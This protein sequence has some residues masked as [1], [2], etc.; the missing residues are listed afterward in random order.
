MKR[1]VVVGA[2]DIVD[3]D[4]IKKYISDDDFVIYC[5]GGYRHRDRLC[6]R[7][8]LI[9]GDFD[10]G[11][12]PHIDVETIVLPREKD[13]TDALYAVKEAL[14]RGFD[15][16]ILLGMTGGR[17]DH[18]LGNIYILYMLYGKGVRAMMADEYS[19]MLMVGASAEKIEDEY[20]YFSLVNITGKA[21]HITIENAKY[22]LNDASITCE[23]QYGF[24]NEVLPHERASVSVKEG[25]LLL[26]KVKK[27]GGSLYK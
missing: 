25:C 12:D 19:E 26:I 11:E 17:I 8:D 5:D 2:A 3:Y 13:D 21:E 9:V 20:L 18:T 22:P 14:E 1:C 6:A 16:F 4:E 24:S 27:E 23:Y 15:D 10:S 7:A